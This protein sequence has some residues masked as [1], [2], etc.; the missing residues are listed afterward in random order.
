[1]A[2]T[3]TCVTLY[4]S[5]YLR[6]YLLAKLGDRDRV[7][8]DADAVSLWTRLGEMLG[9]RLVQ[10]RN[11]YAERPS[12][13]GVVQL[14]VE[15]EDGVRLVP[16]PN[17]RLMHIERVHGELQRRYMLEM[18][19]QVD[20]FRQVLGLSARKGLELFRMQ[21][22]ITEEDHAFSTAERMYQRHCQRAGLSRS[23]QRRSGRIAPG[24]RS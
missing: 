8:T 13:Y 18:Y 24:Q 23:Y 9:G 5:P 6:L 11:D 2:P 12:M 21:Y 4:L 22:S 20:W 15:L 7:A 16:A 14:Y 17:G 19:H 3:P 1:M 10:V